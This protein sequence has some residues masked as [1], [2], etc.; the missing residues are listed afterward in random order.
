[1]CATSVPTALSCHVVVVVVHRHHSYVE[2]WIYLS[3]SVFL[4]CESWS[5]DGPLLLHTISLLTPVNTR[6]SHRYEVGFFF[7]IF[8]NFKMS[9][10]Q[11]LKLWVNKTPTMTEKGGGI[12]CKLD[13]RQ[14]CSSD[15]ENFVKTKMK[16][17]EKG[18]LLM[19]RP[20]L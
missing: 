14:S 18:S 3:F 10:N 12:G 2:G 19:L 1:M 6:S 17:R 4:F 7:L 11:G 9:R 8:A 16:R 20:V 5:R 15:Q 13:W